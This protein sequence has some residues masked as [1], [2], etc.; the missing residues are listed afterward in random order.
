VGGVVFGYFAGITYWFPKIFG[1]R[2]NEKLGKLAFWGWAIGFVLAFTPLYILGLMGATRRMD[3]YDAS[4]GWQ[5]LFIV[6]AVGVGLIFVGVGFQILQFIVSTILKESR[7]DLTGDPWNGRT[8]EWSTTS[9]PPHYNFAVIP[10]VEKRD[11]F[12]E[13]K[14]A[15]HALPKPRYQDIVMP[16]NTPFPMIIAAL[17]FVAGFSVIWHIYWLALLAFIGLLT[18][19]IIRTSDENTEY[20]ISAAQLAKHENNPAGVRS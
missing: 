12:W 13:A 4:L 2:L 15:R 18:C 11:A 6:A 1:F 19:I 16:K 14:Q 8:L 10:E 7:R 5:P 3:H 9:P 20:T 17:A